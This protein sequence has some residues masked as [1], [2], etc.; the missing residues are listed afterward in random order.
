MS[1]QHT[2]AVLLAVGEQGIR[3]ERW[4]LHNN[5]CR[6]FLCSYVINCVCIDMTTVKNL[7]LLSNA[8]DPS[9]CHSLYGI[10]NYTKTTS[11]GEEIVAF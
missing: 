5:C 1:K 6:S 7:E 4:S 11:G 3:R 8:R 10:L 2:T 9:S